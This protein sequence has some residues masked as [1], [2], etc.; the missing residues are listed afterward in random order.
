MLPHDLWRRNERLP[1]TR[2]GTFAPRAR[3]TLV[4]KLLQEALDL[5]GVGQVE[6][7]GLCFPSVFFA[8]IVAYL[9]TKDRYKRL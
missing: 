7:V 1:T 6:F 4:L 9:Y 2:A 8:L 5:P 3:V